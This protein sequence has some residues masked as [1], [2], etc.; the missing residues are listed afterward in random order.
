M[1]LS[2][3]CILLYLPASLSDA[4]HYT[5]NGNCTIYQSTDQA[6]SGMP[7]IHA[8]PGSY[9]Y[10]H[11]ER[12]WDPPPRESS[13]GVPAQP[14]QPPREYPAAMQ[15]YGPLE[16]LGGLSIP[17]QSQEAGSSF[18][19]PSRPEPASP[20]QPP[21]RLPRVEQIVPPPG[22]SDRRYQ[23]QLSLTQLE[24]PA[25]RRARPVSVP[26]GIGS[27]GR[28]SLPELSPLQANP[29]RFS[30]Q[31]P[32]A[33]GS[34]SHDVHTANSS[35]P[36]EE[37]CGVTQRIG[38]S[39]ADAGSQEQYQTSSTHA[40]SGAVEHENMNDWEH[41]VAM[42]LTG[43]GT[44]DGRPLRSLTKNDGSRVEDRKLLEKRRTI[45]KTYE[46]LGKALF[47]HA[48][49]YKIDEN[50]GLRKKQKMYHV[51]ARCRV[52]NAIRKE[53]GQLPADPDDLERLITQR[54]AQKTEMRLLQSEGDAR[55]SPA[56][57]SSFVEPSHRLPHSSQPPAQLRAPGRSYLGQN[58]QFK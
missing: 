35:T 10:S 26:H 1:L 34:S 30:S 25:K 28:A 12:R 53:G 41:V 48:I 46:K 4:D 24:P 20:F 39:T 51:I 29:P 43:Q 37:D 14:V 6:N 52:V 31:Q 32:P 8:E 56:Q 5:F 58:P 47:E 22:L 23:R 7:S 55:S 21:Y 44:S 49:G 33:A 3:C 54:I 42:Y 15:A 2:K 40:Y 11:S 36:S 27:V 17:A 45:G 16:P 38:G 9:S 18:L 57:G 50:T 19:S 13:M